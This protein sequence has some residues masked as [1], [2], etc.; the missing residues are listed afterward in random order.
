VVKTIYRTKHSGDVIISLANRI[1]GQVAGS[2][3]WTNFEEALKERV[4]GL[5]DSGNEKVSWADIKDNGYWYIPA[6]SFGRWSD[7][8][9]TPSK[10]FEFFSTEIELALKAYSKEKS[11]DNALINL[12]ISSKGDEVYMP[13]YEEIKSGT[14]K[15]EYPLLLFPMEL[16]NLASGWI[17]NPP[18]LNK[19]LFNHQLKRDDLFVEVNPKTASQYRLKEGSK[20]IIRSPKGEL[21]V[22]IH[23]FD[24]AMPGVIFVPFG[25]G[26]TAYDKHLKGKGVNPNKIIDQVEDPLSGQPVWWNTRVELIKI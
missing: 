20:A 4:R 21:K 9:K 7:I 6:H 2:F 18:F 1:G 8:F 23:L 17:G 22:K 5:Y 15:K 25:L 13:H 24:G 12:G 14:D 26:H 3:Q 10:K 16:I 19:T 11:F